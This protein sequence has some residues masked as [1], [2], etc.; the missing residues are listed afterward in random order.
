MHRRG[1]IS[2]LVAVLLAYAMVLPQLSL[3]RYQPTTGWDMVSKDQEVQIGQQAA[4][5]TNKQLPV[6]PDSDPVVK[7]VQRLGAE[8]A[9]HAPGDKWPYN[10]HVVNQ[11]EIN[12]FALP[13]GPI[14][15]NL[16]TIQ[17]ADNEAQLAGVMAH[18]ISHVVQRHATRAYTRQQEV[19][20]PLQVLGG[21]MGRGTGAALAQ[22]AGQFAVGSYFLHNSRQNESEADLIGTD[23]MYDTG[24]DPHQMAVF[25]DKLKTQGGSSRVAQFLSDH[26]DP[27]NRAEAVSKEVSS[28][29]PKASY[30]KDSAEFHQI[31]QRVTGMKPLTAQEIAQNQKSGGNAGGTITPSASDVTPS[32]NFTKFQHSAFQISYPENWQVFGDQNSAVTIAPKSGINQDQ[33]AYGVIIDGFQPESNDLD[34]ATHALVAHLRQGNPDLKEVGNDETI[35]VNGVTGKSVDLMGTSPIKDK[36]GKQQR[37][38][39]WLVALPRQD[40][41]LVYAVFIAPESDFTQ[42]RPTYEQML[43]SWHVK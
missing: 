3:A 31:K 6:L 32:G 8:L 23:I 39:D 22:L 19:S 43:R 14:Y 1:T 28:L 21:L 11:K 26:P 38:H 16:G 4:A 42:L 5:Q 34:S 25:F 29:P 20:L 17:A 33:V 24:F 30:L 41:S 36:A 37:E 9:A 27:G 7:Y 12:A 15:V 10:F 40:G 13:G 18:E 35:K 2:R